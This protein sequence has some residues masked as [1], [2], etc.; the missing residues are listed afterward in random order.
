MFRFLIAPKKDK[1]LLLGLLITL[2]WFG[3]SVCMFMIFQSPLK[4]HSP[5][6]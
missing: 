3:F 4:K 6:C 2:V 1:R 5:S